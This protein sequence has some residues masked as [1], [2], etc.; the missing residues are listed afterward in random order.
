MLLSVI[1]CTY[2][3]SELLSQALGS[4]I[5]QTL[6]KKSYEIV[7][8]NNGST[9]NTSD[10]VRSVQ[11]RYK[12]HIINLI[13]EKRLGLG[14]ARNTGLLRAKG[15]YVTFLD[16][17]AKADPNWLQESLR[18]FENIKP[19]PLVVGGQIIPFYSR[20][21]PPWFSDRYEADF[22]GNKSR[23]LHKGESFS[24]SN[25]VVEKKTLL[26]YGGF[27]ENVGMKGN[28]LSVGEETGFFERVWDKSELEKIFYYCPDLKVY[29]LVPPNKTR[30]VYRLKRYFVSGQSSCVR[31][32]K[33][34]YTER[35]IYVSKSIGFLIL[36]LIKIIFPPV[37]SFSFQGWIVERLG[38]V[39]WCLGFLSHFSG[40]SIKVNQS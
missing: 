31:Y 6:E 14:I 13:E 34:K 15:K 35:L 21:K 20:Q 38:P 22:K 7:V 36:S 10:V 28:I 40:L 26:Q 11:R 9:D 27:E 4:L 8:V 18:I 37:Y 23:Y 30:V 12:N 17:D 25:M 16:D 5:C 3:R 33:K 32:G 39:A 19:V 1:I 2:N 29:H 24:G